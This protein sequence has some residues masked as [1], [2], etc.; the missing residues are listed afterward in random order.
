MQEKEAN[1]DSVFAS[2]KFTVEISNEIPRTIAV[3]KHECEELIDAIRCLTWRKNYEFMQPVGRISSG[4]SFGEL[5]VQK[6]VNVKIAHI[7]KKRAA[8]I[9]CRTDCVFA[10]MSKDDYR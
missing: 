3:K 7:A 1:K 6:E 2:E 4:R 9:L 8:S 5:A 10:V